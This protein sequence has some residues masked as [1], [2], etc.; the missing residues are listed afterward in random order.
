MLDNFAEM[1][2]LVTLTLVTVF[3]ITET[4]PVS[5][6]TAAGLTALCLGVALLFVIRIASARYERAM[7]KIAAQAAAGQTPRKRVAVAS[8]GA[9]PSSPPLSPRTD[10]AAAA[11][12]SPSLEAASEPDIEL[13]LEPIPPPPDSEAAETVEAADSRPAASAAGPAPEISVGPI[14][15][16]D[17][18]ESR[19][20]SSAAAAVVQSNSRGLPPLPPTPVRATN[21]LPLPPPP[22]PPGRKSPQS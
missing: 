17:V 3:L 9:D 2:S 7:K 19:P 8:T 11:V 10:L 5:A 16:A 13:E 1:L 15:S 4:T 21:K 18:P 20:D 12:P 6:K 22:P 14:P